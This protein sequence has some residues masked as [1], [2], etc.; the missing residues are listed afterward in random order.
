[1]EWFLSGTDVRHLFI[2]VRILIHYYLLILGHWDG[3]A[4]S[5]IL[6]Q[7]LETSWRRKRTTPVNDKR[8]R[9]RIVYHI[10]V[11][12][13]LF[14]VRCLLLWS[15]QGV[16]L[17]VGWGGLCCLLGAPKIVK[18]YTWHIAR[19]KPLYGWVPLDP[20]G[21]KCQKLSVVQYGTWY[22]T[23]ST[24]VWNWYDTVYDTLRAVT[25]D[26]NNA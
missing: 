14:V 15:L 20:L 19:C 8:K 17:W 26:H 21:K 22:H 11:V 10:M 13:S 9:Q 16:F 25:N 4:T 7:I 12:R 24:K 18:V 2:C 6:W 5:F 3:I 1:M 23:S